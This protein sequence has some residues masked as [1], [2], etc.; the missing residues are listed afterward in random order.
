MKLTYKDKLT[1]YQLKKNGVSRAELSHKFETT[2]S[3][4]RYMVK[5]MGRYGVTVIKKGEILII[6]QN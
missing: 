5:L 3:H 4:I 2:I 6:L 1:L